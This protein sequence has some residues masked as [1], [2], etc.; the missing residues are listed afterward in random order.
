MIRKLMTFSMVVAGVALAQA[1]AVVRAPEFKAGT[2]L[3]CPTGTKQMNG[4]GGTLVACAKMVNGKPV[5][6]G[7][8]VSLYE[9]GKVEAVG[10]MENGLRTG[11]WQMFTQ[12]GALTS[13]IEFLE[14]RYN[15]HRIEYT[16]GKM[17]LDEVYVAGKREGAQKMFNAQGVATIT[18]YRNDRPL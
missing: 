2:A 9:P 18:E 1:P 14:D 15:G 12:D 10:Q 3:S 16:N 17:V 8:A 6:H 4:A 7:P 13:E 11:K 5:F